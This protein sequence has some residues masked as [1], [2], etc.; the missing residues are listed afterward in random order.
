MQEP[1]GHDRLLTEALRALAKEDAA[2]N[3]RR[4]GASPR[5]EA[6]LLAE[7][8]AIAQAR[9]HAYVKVVAIAAALVL[10]AVL[11]VWQAADRPPAPVAGAEEVSTEFFPLMYS[12]VPVTGAHL[13]RME[14]PE[15][16]MASF[17]LDAIDQGRVPMDTVLADVV[18]G[19][20]GLARA[21]SFVLTP[22]QEDLQ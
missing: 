19:E 2:E 12:T 9:R 14:V 11:P 16:V 13:V 7:V 20:D 3:D 10:A 1:E 8:R 4:R 21:V 22:S 6:R 17:G 15:G 5:V 18:I